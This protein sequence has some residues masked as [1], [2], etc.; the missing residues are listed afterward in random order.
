MNPVRR[1]F[2]SAYE[3]TRASRNPVFRAAFGIL[4]TCRAL[5]RLVFGAM[6]RLRNRMDAFLR[7][8]AMRLAYHL[9]A[10]TRDVFRGT[11]ASQAAGW[12]ETHLQQALN[13]VS[14][15]L[16]RARDWRLRTILLGTSALQKYRERIHAS[17]IDFCAIL[18][19][20]VDQSI[21]RNFVVLQHDILRDSRIPPQSKV[22][23]LLR[24]DPRVRDGRL[25]ELFSVFCLSDLFSDLSIHW[26]DATADR[27][28]RQILTLPELQFRQNG[29][30]RR[31][32]L[33]TVPRDTVEDV[34]HFG[35]PCAF[36]RM[37]EARRNANTYLKATFAWHFV[38]AIS[39][40]EDADGSI[41]G[42]LAR[43]EPILSELEREFPSIRITLL[44]RAPRKATMAHHD[45][46]R[47]PY[48]CEAGLT[49]LDA[50]ALAQQANAYF[51]VLDIHGLAARSAGVPGVYM[52]L[53]YDLY[54]DSGMITPPD[55]GPAWRMEYPSLA[56]CRE[57]LRR[58]LTERGALRIQR[59][60]SRSA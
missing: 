11:S 2:R 43:W 47:L 36:L 4:W 30:F 21:L 10:A 48:A 29:Q 57:A 38:V 9:L 3:K 45:A 12:T 51:G 44:N 18:D 50:V 8:P 41:E 31:F 20:P 35:V 14:A 25:N 1:T 17:T 13:I 46:S 23:L 6:M 7:R 5:F 19:Q 52:P 53:D 34:E 28:E 16:L 32:A 27:A 42:E 37:N 55:S 49:L 22:N 40:R 33:S 54:D 59:F 24:I 58:V 39:L 26:E 56:G 60:Y 15:R